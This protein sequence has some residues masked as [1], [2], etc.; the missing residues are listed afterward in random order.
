LK[1]DVH[2]YIKRNSGRTSRE[3]AE[4]LDQPRCQVFLAVYDLVQENKLGY[5]QG[6]DKNIKNRRYS[7]I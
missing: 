1:K 2:E 5:R 4:D 7:A 3:I 6:R